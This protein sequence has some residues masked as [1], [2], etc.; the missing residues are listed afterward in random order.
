MFSEIVKDTQENFASSSLHALPPLPTRPVGRPVSQLPAIRPARLPR[1]ILPADQIFATNDVSTFSGGKSEYL[2]ANYTASTE[3][4]LSPEKNDLQP[5]SI[6]PKEDSSVTA[7]FAYSKPAIAPIS[8]T[9]EALHPA[10]FPG[11]IAS[12][13]SLQVLLDKGDFVHA[14]VYHY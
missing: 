7:N 14:K 10:K 9:N 4:G 11:P 2:T 13:A 1:H 8:P 12:M 3:P 5:E 6:S